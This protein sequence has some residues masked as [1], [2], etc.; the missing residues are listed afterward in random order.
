MEISF[1]EMK[2][3]VHIFSSLYLGNINFYCNLSLKAV[4]KELRQII[5]VKVRLRQRFSHQETVQ[6]L[7]MSYYR[8]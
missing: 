3:Q 6:I 2:A 5:K 4:Y 7:Q 1:T 8:P